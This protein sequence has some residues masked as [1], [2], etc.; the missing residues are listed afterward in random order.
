MNTTTVQTERKTHSIIETSAI[1]TEEF[2][3]IYQ[4][5]SGKMYSLC[6]RYIP[7]DIAAMEIFRHSFS[8]FLINLSRYNNASYEEE[9][10][11]I[12]VAGCLSY[13]NSHPVE[14]N[15]APDHT[16]FY[17]LKKTIDKLPP[18]QQLLLIQL[19]P[20]QERIVYNMHEVDGYGYKE[21]AK[22]LRVS[23]MESR[24]LLSEAVLW[25]ENVLAGKE[26][27]H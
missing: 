22:A 4:S 11:K 12:F 23:V 16:S 14:N 20:Q 26:D 2:R 5:L 25:I 21:I 1:S 15:S 3:R 17:G 7:D 19:L 24:L 18:D 6:L 10:R 8:L 27:K 13:L 9:A